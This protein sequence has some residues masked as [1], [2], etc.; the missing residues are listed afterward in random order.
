MFKGGP[1]AN[2]WTNIPRADFYGAIVTIAHGKF[3]E[4][5]KL[6]DEEIIDGNEKYN[7][8]YQI[9][10]HALDVYTVN[11][12]GKILKVVDEHVRHTQ[13]RQLRKI[14][15]DYV[16]NQLIDRTVKRS[17]TIEDSKKE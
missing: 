11:Q 1:T 6:C 8:L 2:L 4:I 9:T 17:E 13:K 3:D 15:T 10:L 12:I 5:N 14:Q 7:P 16:V